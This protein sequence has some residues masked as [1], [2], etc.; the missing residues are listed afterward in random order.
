MHPC[1]AC[2]RVPI[3]ACILFSGA[4]VPLLI[5]HAYLPIITI[6]QHKVATLFKAYRLSTTVPMFQSIASLLL[7]L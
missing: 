2:M 7:S 5:L 6:L 4:T 1:I 3:C